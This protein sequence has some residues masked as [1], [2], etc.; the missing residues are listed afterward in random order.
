MRRKNLEY[1]LVR[2]TPTPPHV[3]SVTVGSR[4]HDPPGSRH[5]HDGSSGNALPE[6]AIRSKVMSLEKA[7]EEERRSREMWQAKAEEAKEKLK[8]NQFRVC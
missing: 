3:D 7:C 5:R 8:Q 2:A 1:A 4:A 6:G